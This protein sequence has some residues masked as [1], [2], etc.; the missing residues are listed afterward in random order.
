M[1]ELC[2]IQLFFQKVLKA[3]E[4]NNVGKRFGQ[5]Q[6]DERLDNM[7]NLGQDGKTTWR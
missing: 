4:K 7:D 5:Y 6:K 3:K 1:D 2:G